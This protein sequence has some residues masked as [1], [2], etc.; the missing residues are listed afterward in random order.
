MAIK[1]IRDLDLKGKRVLLRAEFN[2]P[3]KD[4]KIL[5]D[6]R[7]RAALPTIRYLADH[8][9]RVLIL[10]HLGRPKGKP[11]P[12]YSVQ[13]LSK[14]LAELLGTDV[15]F[16]GDCGGPAS[17]SLAGALKD[18]QVAL[19]ENTRFYP[20]EEK[21]DPEFVKT[22]AALGDVYVNDAFGAAHRAHASTEGV[23]HQL[24]AAA[25][26]LMEKEIQVLKDSL[27][28]P[29]KPFVV[30]MGGSKV[31]DKVGVI[32][33]LSKK[34]DCML[35]GG[36]MAN[37]LLAAKGYKVGISKIEDDK[38]EL[39]RQMLQRMETS[40]AEVVLPVD[41]VAADRFAAD[42]APQTVKADQIPDGCMALD[43]GPETVRLFEGKLAEAKTVFWNGPLGVY[44]FDAF[45]K[46]SN[47]IAL[48]MGNSGA[49]TI[50]GGGDAVAAVEKA[51]VADRI[52][53]ISTGG[54]ATLEMM[55]GRVLPGIEVLLKQ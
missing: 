33:N 27:D 52:Y 18:G 19:L 40:G 25:G 48:A 31:S 12:E 21:N 36:A 55:E 1:T 30:M 45:A 43:I 28:H 22:L 17:Q 2:V 10:T 13:P 39:C 54:G 35:F 47:A 26:L 4:G 44:E 42:A 34:A 29:E 15:A 50:V 16:A 20:G 32:E 24:P 46:G 14:H 11:A 5:D 53:H 51:G 23:A 49:K 7:M 9:A 37:T 38:L 41:V 8:G 3:L 6:T